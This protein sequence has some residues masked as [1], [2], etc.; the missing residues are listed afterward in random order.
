MKQT[1]AAGILVIILLIS[2]LLGGLSDDSYDLS[3][4][5]ADRNRNEAVI[6]A[7]DNLLQSCLLPENETIQFSSIKKPVTENRLIRP[8]FSSISHETYGRLHSA[9]EY[10]GICGQIFLSLSIS[11][12]IFPF[13]YHW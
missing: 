7:P 5:Q 3:E 9:V 8:A 12:I 1:N 11:A 6:S 13:D 4:T 2:I 10:F